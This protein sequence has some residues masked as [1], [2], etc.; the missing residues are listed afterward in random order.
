MTSLEQKSV[1]ASIR[2]YRR[3]LRI[4]PKAF[5][6]EFAEHMSQVFGDLARRAVGRRGLMSVFVLWGRVVPDLI[7]SAVQ[8]HLDP[9]NPHSLSARWIAACV[10]GSSIG[11]V[12]SSSVN[13]IG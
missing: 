6:A 2:I 8:Q 4:Y 10:L 3:L 11:T 13:A 5:Q 1:L 12:F 7:T 9:A